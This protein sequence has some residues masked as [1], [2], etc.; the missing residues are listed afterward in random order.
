MLEALED[1]DCLSTLTLSVTYGTQKTVTLWGRV[2]DT[3]T[4]GG[5]TVE[6]RGAATGTATTDGDGNYSV[7]LTANQLGTVTAATND[8]QCNTVQLTLTSMPPRIVDFG[9]SV[10]PTGMTTFSGRV[11]D[12]S[13]PGLTV[14][15]GGEPESV[16][17]QTTTVGADG[18]FHFSVLL[19]GGPADNG[20]VTAVVTDWWGLQSQIARCLV[21][22]PLE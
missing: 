6:F 11:I 20:M 21:T 1:R 4:P 15:F 8:E 19:N 7:T 5:V 10:S 13:A 3:P 14:T 16:Q 2:S 17:G 18:W 12:E 9:W 22:Q